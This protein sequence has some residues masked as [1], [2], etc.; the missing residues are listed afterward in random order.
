ML[1]QLFAAARAQGEFFAASCDFN[2]DI[3]VPFLGVSPDIEHDGEQEDDAQGDELAQFVGEAAHTGIG[4]RRRGRP[5]DEVACQG[6][7]SQ[8]QDRHDPRSRHTAGNF[9]GAVDSW[10]FVAQ[11]QVGGEDEQVR[12]R[13][14]GDRKAEDQAKQYLDVTVSG[15]EGGNEDGCRHRHRS[16]DTRH[17][18]DGDRRAIAPAETTEQRWSGAVKRRNGIGAVGPDDPCAAAGSKGDNHAESNHPT[19]NG[20]NRTGQDT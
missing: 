8:R 17:R 16:G 7:V 13:R 20:C 11:N 2:D 18:I 4:N 5:E 12:Q 6:G 19:D 14:R 10:I 9:V 1:R 15:R 3:L